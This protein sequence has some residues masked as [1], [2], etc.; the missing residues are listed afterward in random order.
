MTILIL[1]II[2]SNT[3]KLSALL[4][5]KL[6]VCIHMYGLKYVEVVSIM[7]YPRFIYS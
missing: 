4:I 6:E 7:N 5:V 1:W 3:F 2:E